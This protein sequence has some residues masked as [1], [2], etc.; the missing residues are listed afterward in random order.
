MHNAAYKELGLDF[1]YV[2]IDVKPEELESFIKRLRTGEFLGVSVTVPH[3]QAVLEYLNVQSPNVKSIE[4]VNTLFC[5]QGKLVGEN[6]DW[7]GIHCAL[8]EATDLKG[9]KILI[10]GAGGAARAC[11]FALRDTG[12][13][14]F[15]TN[16]TVEKGIAL[17]NEF[18]ATFVEVSQ[19]YDIDILIN[20]TSVGLH[21]DDRLLVCP[22][23]LK[24]VTIVFDMVYTDTVLEQVAKAAGCQI[25]SGKRMLLY[26]G[27]KQFELF[28]HQKAP[29]EVMARAIGL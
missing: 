22:D 4:A 12:A 6:T 16:R 21:G 20:A 13:E 29:L 26:Q 8:D 24:N 7:F 27:A 28:T 14:V 23:W 19:L 5:D 2:A 1:E 18:N 10:Y 9:K 25:I 15:L 3:K 17:A 11:L